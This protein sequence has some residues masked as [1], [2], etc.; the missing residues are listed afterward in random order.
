[1]RN[2]LKPACTPPGCGDVGLQGQG[3]VNRQAGCRKEAS[4]A[5]VRLRLGL[6]WAQTVADAASGAPGAPSH[7]LCASPGP[8]FSAGG[9]PAAPSAPGSWTKS[10]SLDPFADLGDLSSGLQGDVQDP[11]GGRRVQSVWPWPP[12]GG[13]RA[14]PMLGGVRRMWATW[15]AG[16]SCGG[17]MDEMAPPQSLCLLPLASTLLGTYPWGASGSWGCTWGIKTM[18]I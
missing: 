8:F 15:R 2:V 10:Q 11:P 6:P 14:T 4:Q 3:D 18:S 7:T 12:C 13:L 16:T 9:Q 1:M 5:G 17:R